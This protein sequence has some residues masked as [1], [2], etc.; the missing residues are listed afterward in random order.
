MH[1][2]LNGF[3]LSP[4]QTCRSTHIGCTPIRDILVKVIRAIK[5]HANFMVEDKMVLHMSWTITWSDTFD[6]WIELN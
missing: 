2:G 5:Q 1:F 6:R 4:L 3:S